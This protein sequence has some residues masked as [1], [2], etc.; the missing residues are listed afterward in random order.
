MKKENKHYAVQLHN[1]L[2]LK[3]NDFAGLT[4]RH[5]FVADKETPA[6]TIKAFEKKYG[7]KI[8]EIKV[9]SHKEYLIE[10]ALPAWDQDQMIVWLTRLAKRLGRLPGRR[11]IL[12]AKNG[13]SAELFYKKFGSLADAYRAAGLL[14]GDK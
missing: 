8:V 2:Y 5:R 14:K 13:P 6:A 11:E 3:Q 12:A 4:N 9:Q 7:V 10:D 1:R